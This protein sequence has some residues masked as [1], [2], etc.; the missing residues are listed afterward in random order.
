V[1]GATL[2]KPL[3]S[4]DFFANRVAPVLQH[5]S[6]ARSRCDAGEATEKFI[7]KYTGKTVKSKPAGRKAPARAKA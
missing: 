7:A 4:W 6:M 3:G 5:A 2:R 1:V